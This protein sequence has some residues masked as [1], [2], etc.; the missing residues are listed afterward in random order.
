MDAVDEPFGLVTALP[1][2]VPGSEGCEACGGLGTVEFIPER[3][4]TSWVTVGRS[5]PEHLR[6]CLVC[7]N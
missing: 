3:D 4:A 5:L 1:V 6:P 2:P 7:R